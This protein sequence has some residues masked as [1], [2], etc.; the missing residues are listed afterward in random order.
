[1]NVGAV[2]GGA[3]AGGGVVALVQLW[4]A[5]R[6]A[7]AFSEEIERSGVAPRDYVRAVGV[8]AA[9]RLLIMVAAFGLAG[10]IIPPSF[11][12]SS[13]QIV[14][15]VASAAIV[16]GVVALLIGKFEPLKRIEKTVKRAEA[17]MKPRTSRL[18]G[19][20]Q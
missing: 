9:S 17:A 10:A 16:A 12:P 4:G 7:T 8:T 11:T 5:S 19:A 3:I 15:G 2:V 13:V 6:R 20:R 18:A 1:V 14:I